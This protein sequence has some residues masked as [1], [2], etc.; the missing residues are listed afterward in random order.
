MQNFL[1]PLLNYHDTTKFI[2]SKRENEIYLHHSK[3]ITR[4]VMDYLT[5][6]QS[7]PNDHPLIRAIIQINAITDDLYRIYTTALDQVDL[8]SGL[9]KWFNGVTFGRPLEKPYFFLDES[10]PEVI[11]SAH[12]EDSSNLV[13]QQVLEPEKNYYLGWSPVRVKYHCYT[14]MD[15]LRMS[16]EEE[17]RIPYIKSVNIIEVDLALL[18]TQYRLWRSRPISR[19]EDGTQKTIGQFL[20]TV[21]LPAAIEGQMEIAYFNRMCAYFTGT[22]IPTSYRISR[23]HAYIDTY[24]HVD[25]SIMEILKNYKKAGGMHFDKI[26]GNLPSFIGMDYAK[27]FRYDD[28][29]VFIRKQFLSLYIVGVLPLY[30][31]W[32]KLV[33]ENQWQKWN[34]NEIAKIKKGIRELTGQ[35][36]FQGNLRNIGPH[37]QSL[38]QDFVNKIQ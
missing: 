29:T 4:V 27:H 20:T 38:Y 28:S 3:V 2:K 19:Y 34:T 31:I 15:Y 10:T 33:K 24:K 21:V 11:V 32:W 9:M 36:I 35:N 14:D 13:L 26:V 25:E 6:N 5:F 7:L 16:T 22:H 23:K 17:K 1:Y 37:L 18:Y 30:E 12:F 8:V